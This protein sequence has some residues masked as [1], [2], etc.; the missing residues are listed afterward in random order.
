MNKVF[1]VGRL[2]KAPE[3]KTTPNGVSVAT[4]TLAVN[5]RGKEAGAD[6]LPIVA[7]RTTA[8]L[9]GKYLSKGQKAAVSGEIQT[10]SYEAKDG[11]RRYVT[12]VQADDVEFLAKAG[13]R[14]QENPEFAA[15]M[16][17]MM[18]EDEELPY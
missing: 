13:Q 17:G 15:E 3:L 4:F 7:W 1:L 18:V 5:R 14:A 10:R 2:T 9:C 8:E 11:S 12:E 16:E 6:F